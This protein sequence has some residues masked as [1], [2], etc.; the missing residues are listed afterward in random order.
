MGSL[1]KVLLIGNLGKEPEIRYTPDGLAVLNFSIATS[2]YF[3]TQSGEK[4]EK[5]TWHNIVAFGKTGENV[6]NYLNKGKQVFVEGRISTSSY[7]DKE[8]G[9]KKYRTEI[10][11]N[12]ITLL[13]NK[14]VGADADEGGA[15]NYS[16]TGKGGDHQPAKAGP[17]GYKQE[18]EDDDIPFSQ[19]PTFVV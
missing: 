11:A 5:T 18:E 7:D 9:E 1:N 8:T 4:S 12:L 14:P 10:I 15:G 16:N 2:E 17:Q 13:G 6:A 19:D 3:K